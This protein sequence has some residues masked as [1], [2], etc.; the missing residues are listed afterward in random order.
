M[1]SPNDLFVFLVDAIDQISP[2][3]F[4]CSAQQKT[5]ILVL[6]CR[7]LMLFCRYPDSMRTEEQYVV[8][9][10]GRSN[11]PFIREI[12]VFWDAVNT[13]THAHIFLHAV[14]AWHPDSYLDLIPLGPKPSK[15][16]PGHLASR[17]Q[18]SPST[19]IPR[20]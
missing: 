11:I 4:R 9:S 3:R 14:S 12:G 2:S 10:T 8:D 18:D 7:I 16:Y 5:S 6:F 1:R 19:L 13:R 20:R 17:R 15:T